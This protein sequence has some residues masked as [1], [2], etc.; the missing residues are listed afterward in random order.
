[1][2][3]C[4]N[5]LHELRGPADLRASGHGGCLRC[6]RATQ[7]KYMRE[8]RAARRALNLAIAAL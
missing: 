3:M 4:R 1:M 2:K 6:S 8:C 5:G 7:A